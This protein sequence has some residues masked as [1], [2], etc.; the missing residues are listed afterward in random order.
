MTSA[1]RRLLRIA[2]VL[3]AATL[4]GCAAS[5]TG[6]GS[7]GGG[8]RPPVAD[9]VTIALWRLDEGSGGTAFDSGPFRI[10]ATV[11]LDCRPDFG[12]FG[13]ARRFTRTT[14]SFLLAPPNPVLVPRGGFSCEAWVY[15]T[16]LGQYEITPIAGVWT[17][18]AIRR[19]WMFAI[20]GQRL[21]G[22]RVRLE[23]PGY[24]MSTVP[25]GSAGR[26][27][28]LYQPENASDPLGFESVLPI[29]RERWTHVAATFDGDVVKF[30]INGLLDSQY[31]TRGTM[32]A[33]DAPLLV[34]NYFDTRLLSNFS[35]QLQLDAG[36]PNPYYAFVGS[37]DE[38]RISS[39]AR[40]SFPKVTGN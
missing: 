34:G 39:A 15:L 40:S 4:A 24:F 2:L 3:S 7:R 28:F 13:G 20:G 9:S 31:A 1:T 8:P 37:I 35:G 30:W 12:R 14:S 19:S 10:P 22:A 21:T 29:E 16:E 5:G 27:I 25:P 11:G 26:L 36:D 38:L 32:R 18:D 6:A 17:E 23:S 33:S